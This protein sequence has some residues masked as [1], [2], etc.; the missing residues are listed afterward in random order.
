M[1]YVDLNPIRTNTAKSLRQSSHTSIKKRLKTLTEKELRGTVKA[2]AGNIRNRTM[3]LRLKDYIELVEWT[4]QAIVYPDKA[5]LPHNLSS[6]LSQLNIQQS[7]WLSQIQ[8]YEYNHYRFVGSLEKLEAKINKLGQH[9]LKGMN[10]CQQLF[11][12]GS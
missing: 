2:I 9:W 11:I 1:A 12:A 3:T 4:G 10:Q 6:T 8:T 5:K 7:N